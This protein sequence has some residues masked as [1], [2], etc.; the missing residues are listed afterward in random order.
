MKRKTLRF[1]LI[2]LEQFDTY[3]HLDSPGYFLARD[4][5][6]AHE[7][8]SAREAVEVL[9]L[10]NQLYQSELDNRLIVE[11]HERGRLEEY[12]AGT[13]DE[14]TDLLVETFGEDRIKELLTAVMAQVRREMKIGE[15]DKKDTPYS[16]R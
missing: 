9:C 15:N 2:T 12:G 6:K 5:H 8:G 14:R 3:F 16:R 11:L 1:K 4:A 13:M 7:I 10:A